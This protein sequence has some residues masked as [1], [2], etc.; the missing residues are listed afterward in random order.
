[1][2]PQLG[3]TVTHGDDR[4]PLGE[5]RAHRGVFGQAFAQPVETFGDFLAGMTRHRL[6]TGIDFD[7]GD[8]PRIGEDFDKR[9][10]VMRLLADRL[11]EEDRAADA[12]AQAGRRHDHFAVGAPRLHGLRDA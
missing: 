3:M 5:P 7:A 6:G 9:R 1:M 10:A 4:A 8:D 12:L 11:V 2:Q